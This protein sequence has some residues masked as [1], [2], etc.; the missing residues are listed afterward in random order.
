MMQ[1]VSDG[2]E[3]FLQER[4]PLIVMGIFNEKNFITPKFMRHFESDR[5]EALVYSKKQAVVGL[6][7]TQKMILKGYNMLRERDIRV[8][9]TEKE[10]VDYLLD[11]TI[12]K[13]PS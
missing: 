10:A 12:E 2:R 4:R 5:T 6:T 3:L 8:F 1:L 11:D 13:I 7:E 9:S